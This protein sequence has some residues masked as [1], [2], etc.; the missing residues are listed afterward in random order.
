MHSAVF[1]THVGVNR[2]VQVA[3]KADARIPHA[4]G[5]EPIRSIDDCADDCVFPTHVG[6]N[7]L[8][9]PIVVGMCSIPHACRG[10]LN[11]S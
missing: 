10:E 5:G 7:R 9:K 6:V 1:P 4:C 3:E 2:K 11:Q 8:V